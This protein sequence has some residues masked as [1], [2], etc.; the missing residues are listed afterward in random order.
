MI[1]YIIIEVDDGLLPIELPP[2]QQ[3]DEVAAEL[4]GVLIDEGPFATIEE[5]YDAIENWEAED[6]PA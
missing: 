6:G 2:D 5:A 1:S 3:P 4:G